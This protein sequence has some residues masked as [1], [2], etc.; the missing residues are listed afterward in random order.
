MPAYLP[1]YELV[2]SEVLNAFRAHPS[3]PRSY[4]LLLNSEVLNDLKG[5]VL[6]EVPRNAPPWSLSYTIILPFLLYLHTNV[7]TKIIKIFALFH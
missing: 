2:N 5:K 1:A 6:D 4:S 3:P 7:L